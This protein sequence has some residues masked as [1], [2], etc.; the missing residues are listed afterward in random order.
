MNPSRKDRDRRELHI[1]M[2]RFDTRPLKLKQ[3]RIVVV[4]LCA[5][6]LNGLEVQLLA[7]VTAIILQ[8]KRRSSPCPFCIA[9]GSGLRLLLVRTAKS[10]RALV[11]QL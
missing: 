4:V 11:R 9:R 8:L 2:M 3:H 1:G 6:V 7:F 5:L 10:F